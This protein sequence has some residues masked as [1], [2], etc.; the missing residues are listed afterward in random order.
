V[1]SFLT[2]HS[3]SIRPKN[4]LFDEIKKA[5]CIEALIAEINKIP[6]FN[7]YRSDLELMKFLVNMVE[8]MILDKN[9][10]H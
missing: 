9:Q 1:I 4:S 10:V 5:K 2:Y 6:D 3:D 7:K 8:N